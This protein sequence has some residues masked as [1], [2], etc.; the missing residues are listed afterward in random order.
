VIFLHWVGRFSWISCNA[1]AL[2]CF[3]FGGGVVVFGLALAPL[4]VVVCWGGFLSLLLVC[5]GVLSL[6]YYYLLE[7]VKVLVKFVNGVL[8]FIRVHYIASY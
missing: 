4:P 2:C 3:G 7:Y 6:T 1:F 8:I 5:M